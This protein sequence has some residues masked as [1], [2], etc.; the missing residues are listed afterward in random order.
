[1]NKEAQ[2]FAARFNEVI[3]EAGFPEKGK[4]R[5]A[6]VAK[7]FGVTQ[8]GAR[9]WLEGES[10]PKY[11]R[12]SEM[13]QSL[14][15]NVEWLMSG[16]G[17]R[18]AGATSAVEEK[19][20]QYLTRVGH[21]P[22]SRLPLISWVQAGQWA[23]AV[24]EFAPGDASEWRET[25]AKVSENAF[26][27]KV[28]GDSMVSQSGVSIPEGSIVVVD[29]EAPAD[30]GKIVVAKIA[31]SNEATLKK[32]VID[33]PHKYLKPLNPAYRMIEIDGNCTIVGVVKK[34]EIDL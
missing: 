4:G 31:D 21:V 33:G 20:G 12:L 19:A 16:R 2:L 27:L 28:F 1:M 13:A 17:A 15:V 22:V 23:E 7:H 18:R 25:T 11:S 26:M 6:A 8:K 5:Q 29:P 3:D 14:G 24:E 30:N 9:K 32:L 34:V 10:I